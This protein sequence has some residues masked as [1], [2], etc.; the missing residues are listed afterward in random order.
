MNNELF[1]NKIAALTPEPLPERTAAV[2][3]LL[4]EGPRGPEL[5]LERRSLRLRRQAGEVCLPGGG[6]EPGE[7][8]AD[9]ALRECAEELGLE[10]VQLLSHVESLRH[11]TGERVE[12]YAGRVASL[13]DLRPAPEEVEEVF[14]VPLRWLR[15]HPPATARLALA[16]DYERSSPELHAFLESYRRESSSPLWLWEGKVLWGMS[17]RIVERFLSRTAL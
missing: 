4:W 5:V 13:D 8:P 16:P 7:D 1:Y 9:A 11:R 14:T 3:L 12:V 2:L 6:V 15:E 10:Q 17:A